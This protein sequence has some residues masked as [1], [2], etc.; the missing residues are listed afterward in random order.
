VELADHGLEL[1]DLLA[2]SAGGVAG[3]GREEAERAVAPVVGEPAGR[4]VRLAGDLEER[5]RLDRGDAE[6]AGA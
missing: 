1:G 6:G 3:V 4:Q 5:Q 2:A